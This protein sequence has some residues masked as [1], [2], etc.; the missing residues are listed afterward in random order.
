MKMNLLRYPIDALFI[1][2]GRTPD[3]VRAMPRSSWQ[4][5]DEN[6]IAEQRVNKR[7]AVYEVRAPDSDG[8]GA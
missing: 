5:L 7:V 4:L 1:P 8:S 6:Q 2:V 3:C